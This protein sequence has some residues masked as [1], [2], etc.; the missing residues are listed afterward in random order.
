MIPDRAVH[1]RQF[2]DDDR[3]FDVAHPRAAVFFREDHAEQSHLG[4]LGNDFRGKLRGFV[5]LH[6]VRSDF[7]LGE[8]AHGAAE[9]LLFVGKREFHVTV[10]PRAFKRR[11][12]CNSA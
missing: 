12:Q 9:L 6:H 2:L 10:I 4:Q 11:A 8:F 1:A 5:P 3:V 7:A